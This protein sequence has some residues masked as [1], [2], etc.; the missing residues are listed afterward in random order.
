[1]KRYFVLIVLVLI[2]FSISGCSSEPNLEL[3]SSKATIVNDKNITGSIIVTEG[4]KKGKELTPTALVYE[5][6][7]KN[8]GNRKIGVKR[9]IENDKQAFSSLDNQI[10]IEPNEDLKNVSQEI[11]GINIFDS[12]SYM[13]TGLGYS[14]SALILKPG[15]E[16]KFTLTYDLGV[17]EE[18]PSATLITP[19]EEKLME[20]ESYALDATLVII[21]D[22]TE[23]AS[24]DLNK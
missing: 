12:S 22:N 5:F 9:K 10:I 14:T 21:V 16:K 17:S 23:I 7:I 3:M 20:L 6:T 24:F 2:I 8:K 19:P 11:I 18:S 15:E 4:E 1:M 13:G